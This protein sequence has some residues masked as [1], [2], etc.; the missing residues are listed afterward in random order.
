MP[1]AGVAVEFGLTLGAFYGTLQPAT[2]EALVERERERETDNETG[3]GA[4][5]RRRGGGP[6]TFSFAPHLKL[7]EQGVVLMLNAYEYGSS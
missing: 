3:E 4:Q 1:E 6:H 5:T 2:E 7:G